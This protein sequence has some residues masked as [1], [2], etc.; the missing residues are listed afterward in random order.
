MSITSMIFQDGC[1]RRS[2]GFEGLFRCSKGADGASQQ[3]VFFL[4]SPAL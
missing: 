1:V 2:A 3:R 4:E